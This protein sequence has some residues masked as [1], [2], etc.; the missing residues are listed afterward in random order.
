MPGR[1]LLNS[2]TGTKWEFEEKIVK[3]LLI[4]MAMTSVLALGL[5]SFFVFREGMPI[6]T[7]YGL[8]SFIFGT[9][10][11][12]TNQIYG[13]FPMIVGSI[14]LTIVALVIG[15]PMGIAVAVFLTE[16]APKK[17]GQF[18]RPAIDLLAG[19]PS[20]I[21]GLFGMVVVRQFISEFTRNHL[22][23]TLPANYQTGYS[24]LA[25]GIILS[26]MI[27]PTIINISED[28][29]RSIP[30][31]YKEGALALGASKWQTIY[32]VVVPAA[33]SGI[34]TSIILGMGR[35]L[36][37]TMAVIMVVGNTVLIPE[38]GWK[39]LFS[40]VRSMTGNIAIEM[41]YA[42]PEHRQA[43]FATGIVLFIFIMI[44][45]SVTTVIAKRGNAR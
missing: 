33:K 42:G 31:E 1:A 38:L 6:F 34:I 28:A 25:G 3:I 11:N 2:S 8:S 37:E 26:I 7:K 45:N 14:L 27:L 19:I 43:L 12:P 29:I 40:P 10:W 5:I 22:G 15:A 18:F 16:I 30:K 20:V 44:L 23:S 9:T 17:V 32:K 36:G 41:G 35:A 21:Y 13:I 24:I 39:G 4:I